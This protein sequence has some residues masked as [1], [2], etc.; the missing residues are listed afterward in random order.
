MSCLTKHTI[1]LCIRMCIV[2]INWKGSCVEK[3]VYNSLNCNIYQEGQ[4]NQY[5]KCYFQ[6]YIH[7]VIHALTFCIKCFFC[8]PRNSCLYLY[9]ISDNHQFV[10]EETKMCRY[11]RLFCA[12]PFLSLFSTGVKQRSQE[13]GHL[14]ITTSILSTAHPHYQTHTL[15]HTHMHTAD[16]S[17]WFLQMHFPQIKPD[18]LSSA[19]MF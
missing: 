16:W 17:T 6:K 7:S 10:L 5:F 1:S 19:Y 15:S 4:C 12:K 8:Q 13:S 2:S 14:C 11:F 9:I 3:E 18:I